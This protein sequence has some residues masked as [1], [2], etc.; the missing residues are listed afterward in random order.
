MF[1]PLV[2]AFRTLTI[3]PFPGT[4]TDNRALSLPFFP[5]VGLFIGTLSILSAYLCSIVF[6]TVPF[7]GGIIT[8][9]LVIA[10]TGALHLDGAAD[11]AD[12]FG[13]GKTKQAILE[14]FK[15]SRLGTFGVTTIVFDVLIRVIFLSWLIEHH[16]FDI[17]FIHPVLGRMLQAWGCALIPYAR[18]SGG[19]AL[20]FHTQR[21]PIGLLVITAG[22]IGIV[23]FAFNV[24][25]IGTVIFC[26]IIPSLFFYVYCLNRIGGITG[27]CLGAVNEIAECTFLICG[28]GMYSFIM[29]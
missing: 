23:L 8:T 14:I 19:T 24:L 22:T 2:T 28:C 9:A 3:I 12:G 20:S 1:A 27:D 10:I 5:I 4:D 15:D 18:P 16:H 26:S 6:T 11:V 17:I 21:F 25:P 29:W 13:G 7:A